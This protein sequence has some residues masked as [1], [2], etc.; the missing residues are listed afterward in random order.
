MPF[1]KFNN[2]FALSRHKAGA[3]QNR[4]SRWMIGLILLFVFSQTAGLMHAEVHAFH[5]HEASCDVFDHLAQPLNHDASQQIAI[6]EVPFATPNGLVFR[7][8]CEVQCISHFLSRAP[9]ILS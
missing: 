2:I 3:V 4:L 6:R 7:S 8:V 9:P 1:Y 5:E